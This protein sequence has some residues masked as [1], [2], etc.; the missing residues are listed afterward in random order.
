M[1]IVNRVPRGLQSL[2]DSK[3]LG[4]NPTELLQTISPVVDL[5]PFWYADKP[6][7]G[8]SG[9]AVGGAVGT[10][11]TTTVPA[12]ELWGV[13]NVSGQAVAAAAAD[14]LRFYI[15]IRGGFAS[16]IA[17]TLAAT[18]SFGPVAGANESENL[19]WTTAVP[20]LLGPG[21]SFDVFNERAV[22]AGTAWTVRVAYYS[23]SI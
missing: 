13:V 12:G 14:V 3:S 1:S 15:R 7:L 10:L 6:L 18:T 5:A 8:A 16:G 23:L 4:V 11:A 19:G 17:A 2:L 20:L 22:N 9:T 21:T